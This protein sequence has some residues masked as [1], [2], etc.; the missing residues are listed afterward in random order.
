MIR[1]LKSVLVASA[2]L[3]GGCELV[4]EEH[5]AIY[6]QCEGATGA[7]PEQRIEA[8]TAAIALGGRYAWELPYLYADRA[9]A[10]SDLDQHEKA[11]AD[12]SKALEIKPDDATFLVGR[13]VVHVKALDIRAAMADFDAAIA[14]APEEAYAYRARGTVLI[15]LGGYT[16]GLEDIKKV[17]NLGE[18][19][20]SD[21]RLLG[22]A[23]VRLDQPIFAVPALNESIKLD[24]TDSSAF[25]LRSEARR[26]MFDRKGALS[27][28]EEAIRLDPTNHEAFN[29]RSWIWSEAENY[30]P[31]IADADEAARLSPR[32][33]VYEANRC[34][35]RLLA[36][37][38]LE[39]AVEGCTL[40]LELEPR[41]PDVLS[42]RGAVLL[43][44]ERF[45]AAAADFGACVDD[46]LA[47]PE[48]ERDE[49]DYAFCLHGRS[50]VA[51][52]TSGSD[53]AARET[54][55]KSLTEA[56]ELR[57]DVPETFASYGLT[58]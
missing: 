17:V 29:A 22:R 49:L 34:S 45:E 10:W 9:N 21:Y 41:H 19:N 46:Q 7:T 43:L 55:L 56:A 32:N 42:A 54:A 24:A 4:T 33:F 1:G 36:G 2:L 53:A 38:D 30:P 51:L 27:D 48:A 20:A 39:E 31:A 40:A 23:Y 58:P 47:K 18:A 14:A 6:D 8:C 5:S 11:A 12:A 57:P 37:T 13:A 3:A 28:A 15:F 52:K 44:L 25:A 35:L 50:L 26:R 16:K